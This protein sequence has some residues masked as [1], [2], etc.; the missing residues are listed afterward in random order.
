MP[1]GFPKRHHPRM[2]ARRILVANEFASYRQTI[3]LVIRDLHPDV[4]VF[5]AASEVLDGEVVAPRPRP[6]DLQPRDLHGQAEGRKLGRTLPRI[7][8]LLDLLRR[9]GT[10]DAEDVQLSDLLSLVR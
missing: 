2:G 8:A 1:E 5:E 4:E 3:A 10:Q 7:Q 6:G 9:R